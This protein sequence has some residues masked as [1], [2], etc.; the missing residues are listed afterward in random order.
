[1]NDLIFILFLN[2]Y[3][4][5]GIHRMHCYACV[6]WIHHLWRAMSSSCSPLFTWLWQT[7]KNSSKLNLTTSAGKAIKL[8]E[9]L[10]EDE[11]SPTAKS[12]AKCL[13][14][15]NSSPLCDTTLLCCRYSIAAIP[16]RHSV[17]P[18]ASSSSSSSSFAFRFY[19]FLMHYFMVSPVGDF[20]LARLMAGYITTTTTTTRYLC[21]LH[22]MRCHC[23]RSWAG[24]QQAEERR[25]RLSALHNPEVVY[26]CVLLLHTAYTYRIDWSLVWLGWAGGTLFNGLR[27]S[28]VTHLSQSVSWHVLWWWT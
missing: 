26:G 3:I 4:Q 6:N 9:A 18:S 16:S 25:R 11:H 23:L 17:V 21:S 2:L 22:R 8:R 14:K 27:V 15:E 12:N 24:R 7:K 10:V 19:V 13:S 28:K 20:P 1:M 5:Q